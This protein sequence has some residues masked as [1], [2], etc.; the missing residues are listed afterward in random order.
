MKNSNGFEFYPG[1]ITIIT[2]VFNAAS[3]LSECVG[4]VLAQS[5]PWFEMLLINDGST[6]ESGRICDHYA[7]LDKR[8]S[9]VHKKNNGPASARNIGIKRSRGEFILFLDADD[10]L[11]PHAIR[12]LLDNL[13]EN[14]ADLV[15]GN[16]AK[17]KSKTEKTANTACLPRHSLTQNDLVDYARAYLTTPHKCPLFGIAWGKLFKSAIIKGNNIALDESL[18]NFD[19]V[20]FLFDYLKYVDKAY[21]TPTPIY[22]YTI[23]YA[24]QKNYSSVCMSIGA[25]P[26]RLFGYTVALNHV[27]DFLRVRSGLTADQIEREI[28]HAYVS[29]TSIQMVRIG[30]QVNDSNKQAIHRFVKDL[31]NNSVL[32]HNLRFYQPFKGPSKIL[33]LLMRLK[34]VGL[35]IRV[36]RRKAYNK[37][38]KPQPT[39]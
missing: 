32:R 27:K 3:Y 18:I 39:R 31:V 34:L 10:S 25:N 38:G 29:I 33:P 21:F 11:E 13:V 6:D 1:L 14:A 22:N 17:V 12:L 30:G 7:G 4:S 26:Q 19:D 24:A 37:Y 2:P 20:A 23:P 28:G 5:Y 8:I 36:S 35:L 9:V 16:F 15:I